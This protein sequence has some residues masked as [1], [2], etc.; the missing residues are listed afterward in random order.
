MTGPSIAIGFQGG[1]GTAAGLD[2]TFSNLG[3]AECKTIAYALA[4]FGIVIGT[5][6]CL[7]SPLCQ[8]WGLAFKY[9]G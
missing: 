8:S 6:M 7:D 4:T 3:F 2:N 1:H 9:F 5:G